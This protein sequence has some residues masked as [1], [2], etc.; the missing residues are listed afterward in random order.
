MKFSI[1]E[2]AEAPFEQLRRQVVDAV[3]SGEL[4]AGTRMPT[5]RALAAELGLATNT[6]AK[7]YRALEEDEVIETRGRNGSFVSASGDPSHRQAQQ[8]AVAYAATIRR[9]RLDAAEALE[10]VRAALK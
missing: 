1:V 5:V 10:L 7:A 8:A 2:G 6:V 9:L 3:H 4:T